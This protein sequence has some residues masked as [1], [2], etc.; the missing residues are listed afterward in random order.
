MMTAKIGYRHVAACLALALTVVAARHVRAQARTIDGFFSEF[1]AE[2]VRGNPNLTTSTRYFTGQEQERLERQ[3]TPETDAYRRAR[4]ALARRGL[5]DLRKFNRATMTDAERLAADLMDWQLET[6]VREEPFLDYTF[7]LEQ[8]N[9]LNVRVIET[10]TVRHPLLTEKD[11]ENY[12][13]TLGQVDDR[14]EEAIG[15]VPAS[16]RER[17]TSTAVHSHRHHHADAEFREPVARAESV[18][19]GAGREDGGREIDVGGPARRAAGRGRED[20][21][22]AG[23]SGLEKGGCGAW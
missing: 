8:M 10:L 9:G 12:V 7:P 20:R 23:L 18:R 16:G 13:A 15:E 19:D 6:V 22:G 21:R 5:A 14:M 17:H 11:A 1:T 3:L 4:I 2:W